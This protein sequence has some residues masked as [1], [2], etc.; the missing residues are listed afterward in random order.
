MTGR[1]PTL[2]SWTSLWQ[3]TTGEGVAASIALLWKQESEETRV[4][5]IE[6]KESA[7]N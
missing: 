7:E 2:P 3:K 5:G 6:V 1:L 4:R